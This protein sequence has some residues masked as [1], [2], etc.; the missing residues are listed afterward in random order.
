MSHP[1]S[2]WLI[3]VLVAFTG[4]AAE[5]PT[6]PPEQRGIKPTSALTIEHVVTPSLGEANLHRVD[7]SI[8]SRKPM[9][10]LSLSLTPTA[11]VTVLEPAPPS[12]LGA[13]AVGTPIRV[14]FSV[15]LVD[16][17]GAVTVTLSD[18]NGS[19]KQAHVVALG[20]PAVDAAAEAVRPASPPPQVEV[21]PQ[22]ERV[23]IQ[24]GTRVD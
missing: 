3:A 17:R 11:G 18:P 13:V 10:A 6:P 16:A 4:C 5:T 22:G 21:T 19:R 20:T 15:R 14:A 1:R 2:V 7:L 8:V 12:D 24:Q 23:I 9:P